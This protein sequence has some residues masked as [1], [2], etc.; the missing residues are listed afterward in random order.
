MIPEN[1]LGIIELGNLNIKCLIFNIDNSNTVKILSSSKIQSEGIHNS[2]IINISKATKAIRSCIGIAE[3]KAEASLKRI[4]VVLEQPEFLCTKLSK[5]RKIDGSKI[6]KYD[7]D[8]LLKEAKK[9]VTHNDENQSIILE[10]NT[11]N[12]IN[13][14]KVFL[15]DKIYKTKFVKKIDLLNSIYKE[16]IN[17]NIGNFLD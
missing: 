2:V 3:K 6:K 7:I 12:K 5:Q 8:F 16:K 10:N 1:P 14:E 4:H 11:A 13:C 15:T 9:Q 17:K